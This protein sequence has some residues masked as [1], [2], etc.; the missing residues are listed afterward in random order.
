M[1]S[2]R[3]YMYLKPRRVKVGDNVRR[4]QI[5]ALLGNSGNPDAPHLHF[6][7][8]DGNSPL[9]AEGVPY[10]FKS[11]YMLGILPSKKLLIEGGW[12]PQPR[13]TIDKRLSESPI[14]NAV[15]RF[16]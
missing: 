8:T 12:K 4:G 16:P 7:I 6:H 5:L 3:F 11:F 14:E 13:S 2:F 15:V 10:V 1:I 9:G